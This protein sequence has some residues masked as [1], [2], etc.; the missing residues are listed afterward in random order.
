MV[1][2]HSAPRITIWTYLHAP[3]FMTTAAQRH[4][5]V[6]QA[7]VKGGSGQQPA[8]GVFGQQPASTG[9]GAAAGSPFG[10][11]ASSSAAFQGGAF[12]MSQP[13]FGVRPS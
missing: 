8:A 2:L 11:P 9:F 4:I 12:G 13:A 1:P 6:E 3:L 5:H 10:S 7:G